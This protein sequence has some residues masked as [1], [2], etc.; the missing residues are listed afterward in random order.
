MR[1]PPWLVH[2]NALMKFLASYKTW[3]F[4]LFVELVVIFL[5]TLM[6]EVG[7]NFVSSSDS[8]SSPVIYDWSTHIINF[9]KSISPIGVCECAHT[10]IPP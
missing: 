8:R 10:C 3:N 7:Q 9:A 1:Y 2:V 4:S 6:P 5:K